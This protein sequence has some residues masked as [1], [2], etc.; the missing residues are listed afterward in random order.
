MQQLSGLFTFFSYYLFLFSQDWFAIPQEVLQADWHDVWHAPQPPVFALS[1][2]LRVF[3]E[4]ILFKTNNSSAY[5]LEVKCQ[6]I[7]FLL[8]ILSIIIAY[9]NLYRSL[10]VTE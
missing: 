6:I 9:V 4:M 3:N 2:R 10:H 5:I 8:H 1:F 7:C